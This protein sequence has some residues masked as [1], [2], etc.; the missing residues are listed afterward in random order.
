[1]C[2]QVS[3]L[4]FPKAWLLRR[5]SGSRSGGVLL[6]MIL[7]AFVVIHACLPQRALAEQPAWV[8]DLE[9]GKREARSSGKNLL[10]VFTGHGH[11]AYCDILDREVFQKSWFLRATKDKYVFVELDYNFGDTPQEKR[12]QQQ[13]DKLQTQYLIHG[14]PTVVLA[15]PAGIPFYIATGYTPKAGPLQLLVPIAV[16]ERALRARDHYFNLARS[17]HGEERLQNLHKG[18]QVIAPFLGSM[19]ERQNDPVLVFYKAQVEEIVS[20]D[21]SAAG[22]MRAHYVAERK[23]RDDWLAQESVFAKLKEFESK[24]DNRGAIAYVTE[25]LRH[26]PDGALRWRLERARQVYLEWDSQF[27]IALANAQRLL[28]SS[29]LDLDQRNYLLNREAFNLFR[30]GRIDEG[31]AHYDRRISQSGPDQEE[32]RHLLSWKAQMI[33][34][35]NRPEQSVQIWREYR[36]VTKPGSEEWQEATAMLVGEL[37]KAGQHQAAINLAAEF[38]KGDLPAVVMLDVA[39]SHLK[40]DEVRE[41][42]EQISAIGKTIQKLKTSDRNGDKEFASRLE[43]RLNKLRAR[44][45]ETKP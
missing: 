39:E 7:A 8:R 24:R 22:T 12:R 36:S 33:L 38:P 1:M 5:L 29:G 28:A 18:I 30:L 14:I 34:S 40:L 31:L 44:L 42:R 32:R 10:I 19:S 45:G 43:A 35:R 20:T 6:A 15:D 27:A 23:K 25:A 2:D 9:A 41:A 16:A 3:R 17:I 37:Q 11:C 26:T 4:S 13:F 21:Q